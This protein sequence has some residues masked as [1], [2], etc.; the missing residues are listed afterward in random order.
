MVR[1]FV[2]ALML[3]ILAGSPSSVASGQILP[4]TGTD[5]RVLETRLQ[6]R[7]QI[8]PIDNGVVLTPK[9]K[10]G[11]R[12]VEVTDLA[13]AVDG[14]VVTGSELR[15]KL[16]TDSDLIFQLSYLDAA[17]RRSLVGLGG[18]PAAPGRGSTTEAVPAPGTGT[19]ASPTPRR[20]QSDDIVR[21]GGSVTIQSDE[22]VAGDVVVIGGG[23]DIDGQVERD[24]TVIGG[25]L[26]LGPHAV[27]QRNVTVVGGRLNKDP[28]ATIGGR[29]SEVG[30]G[31]AL[32]GR[33]GGGAPRYGWGA[34]RGFG[35]S[36]RLGLAGTLVRVALVMLLAGIVLL[37]ARTP[38]EQ[39]ADRASAEPF[40]SWAVGFLA[41]LLFVPVL[42]LTVV[43]LAVSII[44][45][46]LLLLVPVAIVAGLI[47]CL[48]GFTGVAYHVGRL[49][50]ARFDQIRNRP[51]LATNVGIAV[52]VAPLLLARIIG[53]VGGLGFIAGIFMVAGV[54][55]EYVAWT[56]GLGAAALVR[57]G[58]PLPQPPAPI[59]A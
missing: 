34:W 50:E 32:R 35:L 11:I 13:I 17:S 9:F 33:Q 10:T 59:P 5:L 52:I 3:A 16:G 29:V 18:S 57:F 39:I 12:A 6:N 36:P 23:A 45:I 47:A 48:V 19:G 27:V 1:M 40:K 37:V 7:F 46:P 53:L 28:N 4:Q 54:V 25:S 49:V 43:A 30:V 51:Y 55:L 38:V 8:L 21:F 22:T 44:G 20:R 2:T 41:E 56:T 31:D 24:V 26:T 58:R 42:V 14:T 15:E